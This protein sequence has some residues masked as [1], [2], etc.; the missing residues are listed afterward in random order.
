ICKSVPCSA[1]VAGASAGYGIIGTS[2]GSLYIWE[3]ATGTKLGYLSHCKGATIS[4]LTGDDSDSGAFAVAVDG[5]QLQ[6]YAPGTSA[7]RKHA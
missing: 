5:S 6:V 1:T 7:N 3:L 2:N 4:C